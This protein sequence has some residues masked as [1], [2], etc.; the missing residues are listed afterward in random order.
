MV[1]RVAKEFGQLPEVVASVLDAAS[2]RLSP[3]ALTLLSYAE[4]HR[5]F[6]SND[7]KQIDEFRKGGKALMEMVERNDRLIAGLEAEDEGE[8]GG[9]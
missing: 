8:E 4:A 6:R 9:E 2:E 5:V 7:R 3:T 1:T